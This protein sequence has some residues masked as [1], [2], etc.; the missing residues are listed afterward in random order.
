MTPRPNRRNRIKVLVAMFFGVI[1]GA[2]G[3]VCLSRG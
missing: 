3:N 1:F 2:I